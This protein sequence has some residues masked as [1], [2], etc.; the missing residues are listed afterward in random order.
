MMS[1][2]REE[3]GALILDV[4]VVPRASRDRF[5]PLHGDRIKVSVTS[6]PVDGAANEALIAVVAR[7][8]G[9]SRRE[10]EVIAGHTSRRKRLRVHGATRS[11]VEG[12]L[13]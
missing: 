7:A 6:P 3:R 10:V 9:R 1:A 5:G 13:A 12:A 8:L 11:E 4:L 2:I